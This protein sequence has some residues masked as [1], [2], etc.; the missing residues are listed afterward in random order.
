[1][2]KRLWVTYILLFVT[3]IILMATVGY[4][5]LSSIMLNNARQEYQSLLNHNAASLE[6]HIQRLRYVANQFRRTFWVERIVNHQ[7]YELNPSR[8]SA[9]DLIH[10]RQ[11][12]IA[13]GESL[14][15]VS[16][17]GLFFPR[18][19][20]V[21]AHFGNSDFDFLI[22]NAMYVEGW[23][24]DKWEGVL[25]DLPL[26]VP[27]I[28]P[29]LTIQRYGHAHEKLLYIERIQPM[30]SLRPDC[31]LFATMRTTDI[32]RHLEAISM[33]GQNHI[34]IADSQG[35]VFA[36]VG[37][38]TSDSAVTI[39]YTSLY[40]GWCYVMQIPQRVILREL[41]MFRNI[42]LAFVVVLLLVCGLLSFSFSKRISKPIKELAVLIPPLAPPY[43]TPYDEVSSLR[44]GIKA[45]LDKQ[46]ELSERLYHK[47]TQLKDLCM[48]ML[49]TGDG[50]DADIILKELSDI[51]I[52]L[53]K[54][55]FKV[56]VLSRCTR[57]NMPLPP[58]NVMEIERALE[59]NAIVGLCLTKRTS[60]GCV[61]LVNYE[62]EE[63]VAKL[64]TTLVNR[65]PNSVIKLG[66][67]TTMPSDI[68]KS[69]LKAISETRLARDDRSVLMFRMKE[70]VDSFL[71]NPNLSLNM[72]A[73]AF[74]VSPSFVSKMFKRKGDKHFHQYVNG[75]RIDLAKAL[76]LDSQ[77]TML[78]I[79]RKVGYD[80]DVT[81]RRQ[82][83]LLTGVTPGIFRD[84][85]N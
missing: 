10:F 59:S 77:L 82:F 63:A 1:M 84:S 70:Y 51:N 24:L 62:S 8:I 85:N 79:A 64:T 26:G 27:I 9:Y 11:H 17:L 40:T 49:L 39:E 74:D 12:V 25:H 69:Y 61:L 14:S 33:S 54:P 44:D 30:N 4:L 6:I 43:S 22:N 28:A 81:F 23:D 52:F 29:G 57:T 83:K 50:S 21:I 20:L 80:S 78:E 41:N 72:V 73:N 71:C 46:E 36:G 13:S 60:S 38:P 56:A 15:L 19:D 5:F 35:R 53:D 16:E 45:L 18:K 55:F 65:V 67:E 76:L 31:V 75:L 66:D 34:T 32:N 42:L 68:P 37:I 3:P 58:L 2:Q 48:T 47:S 7:G